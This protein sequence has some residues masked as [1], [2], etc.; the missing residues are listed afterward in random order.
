MIHDAAKITFPEVVVGNIP[1]HKKPL[2][3]RNV[4]GDFLMRKQ[5]FVPKNVA[6]DALCTEHAFPKECGWSFSVHKQRFC[7]K[8]EAG[9]F[10]CM[11]NHCSERNWLV[12]FASIELFV[13]CMWLVMFYT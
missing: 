13:C 6:G 7:L 10:L 5:L 3:L 8:H 4:A 11:Q 12:I 1:M 9:D 2:V